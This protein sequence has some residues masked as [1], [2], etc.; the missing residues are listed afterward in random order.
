[1]TV[2]R[3][4]VPFFQTQWTNVLEDTVT[5]RTNAASSGTYTKGTGYDG[6]ASTVYSGAGLVRPAGFGSED[7]GQEQIE[8]VDYHVYLPHGTTGIVSDMQ[9]TVDAVGDTLN[10]DLLTKTLTVMEI[11]SDS[12]NARIRLGC[13]MDRGSGAV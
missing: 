7:F 3:D 4:A 6:T 12:F 8:T 9:V 10:A 5:I 2:F 1:M 11:G 13:V